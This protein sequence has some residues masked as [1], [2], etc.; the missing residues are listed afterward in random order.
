MARYAC[1]IANLCYDCGG[2]NVNCYFSIGGQRCIPSR[3][4]TAP[5]LLVMNDAVSAGIDLPSALSQEMNE[6]C[7]FVIGISRVLL[8]HNV[9]Q[10]EADIMRQG[11]RYDLNP[12][13]V[14]RG[15]GGHGF[16]FFQDKRHMD[17]FLTVSKAPGGTW[18][19]ISVCGTELGVR[20]Y[21]REYYSPPVAQSGAGSQAAC[22]DVPVVVV[23]AIAITQP[24]RQA[25]GSFGALHS[26]AHR[27][28]IPVGEGQGA[29]RQVVRL[30]IPAVTIPD[31]SPTMVEDMK[32]GDFDWARAS[33]FLILQA[34]GASYTCSLCGSYLKRTIQMATAHVEG[35]TNSLN[36]KIVLVHLM[37][38]GHRRRVTEKLA[39]MAAAALSQSDTDCTP[40]AMP[41]RTPILMSGTRPARHMQHSAQ[42]GMCAHVISQVLL[43]AS[44]GV[45]IELTLHD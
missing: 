21:S 42:P 3:E 37:S 30:G 15:D 8:R 32:A 11:R 44:V 28:Q 16:I 40:P 35:G 22:Q 12:R 34:D 45:S 5:W 26:M 39:Q 24:N 43:L 4:N 2:G 20:Q 38:V 27:L 25:G 19:S 13:V 29:A 36:R 7:V 1:T 18:G 41:S 17:R 10:I 31:P 14:I 6:K 33:T 9:A 23:P